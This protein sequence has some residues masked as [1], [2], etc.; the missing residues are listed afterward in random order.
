MLALSLVG[1]HHLHSRRGKLSV[2]EFDTRGV[3]ASGE[4]AEMN[5]KHGRERLERCVVYHCV[6]L[7]ACD[8]Q[9]L[10]VFPVSSLPGWWSW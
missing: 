2:R 4:Q 1:L 8:W 10:I 7:C 5:K 6:E 9:T 3:S